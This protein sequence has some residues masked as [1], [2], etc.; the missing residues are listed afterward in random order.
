MYDFIIIVTISSASL[1]GLYSSI[2]PGMIFG[3][4]TDFLNKYIKSQYVRNPLGTC[5]TCMSSTFGSVAYW[6]LCYIFDYTQ[7]WEMWGF[8]ILCIAFLATYLDTL[9]YEQ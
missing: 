3:F 1:V 4:Y 2:Y 8:A 7:A 6:V 9:I 5:I